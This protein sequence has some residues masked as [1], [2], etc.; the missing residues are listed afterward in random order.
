MRSMAGDV[1]IAL[2]RFDRFAKAEADGQTPT[3][4]PARVR[5]DPPDWLIRPDVTPAT[6]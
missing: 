1:A 6:P 2:I 5:L 3:A 4:G